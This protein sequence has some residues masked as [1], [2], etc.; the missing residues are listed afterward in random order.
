MAI[1]DSFLQ[2]VRFGVRALARNKTVTAIA[3]VTLALGIGANTTIFT[4]V[5]SLL[6]RPLPYKDAE[7]LVAVFLHE[8]QSGERRLPTSS[9]EF[10][11][12]KRQSATLEYLTAATPWTPALTGTD[13]PDELE[14]LKVSASLFDLLGVPPMLGRTFRPEEGEPG[15]DNVVVLG[16]GLWQRRFGGDRS[17]VGRNIILNGLP[18]QVVG[19]MPREFS[20]PPFWQVNAEFWS[21][22]AFSA[23]ERQSRNRRAY[24]VFARLK[25]GA[26]IEQAQQEMHAIALRL[27]EDG[28]REN[29]RTLDI[30]VEPLLEPVVSN[31]RPALL[32][33]LGAVGFLL[34]IA[35]ANVANLLLARAAARQR[36]I[37]VRVALGASRPRLLRQLLTE[38]LLLGV[39]G[40]ALGVGVAAVGVRALV[41]IGPA[42]LPRL[43]EISPDS[44]VL[45]FSLLLSMIASCLFGL[46]P[47]WQASRA[48]L[49]DTMKDG[50]RQASASHSF[51]RSALVVSEVALALV[52]LTGA[53]LMLRSFW[54]ISGVD[55]GVARENVLTATIVLAG[56]PQSGQVQQHN[57]NEELLARLR[58]TPGVEGAGFISFLHISGDFWRFMVTLGDR[59]APPLEQNPRA[60]FKVVS[61]GFFHAVGTPVLRGRDF[62]PQDTPTSERVVIVNKTFAERFWPGSN[63]VGQRIK[64]GTPT[65][66]DPWMTIAGVVG[67]IRQEELTNEVAPEIYIP[68]A[69]NIVPWFGSTTLVVR[70]QRDALAL[71]R[72][73]QQQVWAINPNLPVT[74][75]RTFEQI[76]S[77]AVAQ[78]RFNSTLILT[79]AGLALLLSLIGIYGV[80]SYSV[81]QRAREIGIRSA[82]GAQPRQIFGLVIGHG[83]KLAALGLA[84]GLAG[85]FA[86]TRAL[87]SLLYGVSPSDPATFLAVCMLLAL[88]ASAAAYV[89]ARRATRVDPLVA[90]RHE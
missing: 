35:C 21:P 56:S 75:I 89:P 87:G 52:L 16:H 80:L 43:A 84:I 53:G 73:V 50:G 5:N 4:V 71:T 90:L 70:A 48:A 37:A 55:P 62:G 25:P 64:T 88:V 28:H 19:V 61:P 85:A 8:T 77:G 63:P 17:I 14:G 7:R 66:T 31:T 67:D 59:P 72:S 29:I 23:E 1:I 78:P 69:Q 30:N 18:H 74:R 49:H 6:L 34:L 41:A 57:F 15:N 27:R 76:L 47:A 46:V 36:E 65:G 26:T 10:H 42:N 3:L 22:R 45:F 54:N 11:E 40:G 39:F 82:L 51:A 81:E 86:L 33:L 79:F 44:R 60:S 13:Q 58:S 2:D 9:G 68:Y 20:F 38:S 12:W 32:V 24:R 83:L